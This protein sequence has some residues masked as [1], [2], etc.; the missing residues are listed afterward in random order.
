MEMA[1]PKGE[2]ISMDFVKIKPNDKP[3]YT[4]FLLIADEQESMVKTYLYR[5]DMFALR[6]AEL[7]ALCIKKRAS[8]PD[9][10]A[11]PPAK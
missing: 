2:N 8:P 5:G 10:F 11:V 1:K 4:K 3:K 6:D 9:G 7:K